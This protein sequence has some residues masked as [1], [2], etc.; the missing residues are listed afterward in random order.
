MGAIAIVTPFLVTCALE[1]WS[2][3]RRTS[4][5]W[6]TVVGS[7]Q[8]VIG[9][10]GNKQMNLDHNKITPEETAYIWLRYYC[11]VSPPNDVWETSAEIPYWWHVS[12]WLKQ[13]SHAARPI[14]STT[15]MWEV[16]VISIE[17]LRSF[18]RRH[19]AGKPV[20]ASPTVGC[21]L[22]LNKIRSENIFKP[23]TCNGLCNAI[24]FLKTCFRINR[25]PKLK[26]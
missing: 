12:N 10:Y 8:T 25:I 18:L 3:K 2:W 26:V 20:V 19:L 4:G 6:V 5:I 7:R 16:R 14:R 23:K 22:R 24:C 15:Q 9:Y 11:M 13:I 1:S 17:F 21:I